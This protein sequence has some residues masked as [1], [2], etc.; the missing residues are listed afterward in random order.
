M[1]AGKTADKAAAEKAL[2]G[3]RYKVAKFEEGGKKKKTTS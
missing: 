3:T 1:K 2:K